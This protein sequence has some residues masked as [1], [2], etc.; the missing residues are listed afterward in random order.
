MTVSFDLFNLTSKLYCILL[1][2]KHHNKP[3]LPVLRINLT[4]NTT[5]CLSW[6]LCKLRW[7]TLYISLWWWRESKKEWFVSAVGSATKVLLQN[8][9]HH[10]FHITC[11]NAINIF[12]LPL[13]GQKKVQQCYNSIGDRIS[14]LIS[15]VHF[16]FLMQSHVAF[17]SVI[18]VEITADQRQTDRAESRLLKK[19]AMIV[20]CTGQWPDDTRERWNDFVQAWVRSCH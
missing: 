15:E 7:W 18:N 11:S 14:G 10:N 13:V 2:I 4:S 20:S 3:V 19:A 1:V 17:Y 16:F 5:C 12:P 6:W 8:F 9:Q